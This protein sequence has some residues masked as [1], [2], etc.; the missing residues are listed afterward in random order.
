MSPHTDLRTQL[1]AVARPLS[2]AITSGKGGVGKSIIA[3]SL[4]REQASHGIRTLLVDADLGLGNLHILVDRRPSFTI[5][6]VLSSRCKPEDAVL[7]LEENLWMIAARSGFADVDWD[8]DLN[9]LQVRQMLAW[10]KER[11]SL[12]VFDSGAGI[13]SKVTTLTRLTDVVILV[14]TTEVSAIA[15]SYAVAKYLISEDRS[16]RVGLVVNRAESESEGR[17]TAE[18]VRQMMQKFLGYELPATAHI[19]E[20]EDSSLRQVLGQSG[21]SAG[22]EERWRAGIRSV[23]RIVTECVPKDLSLWADSHWGADE[24]VKK[25]NNRLIDVDTPK[26]ASGRT[27]R[28]EL[29]PETAR[30]DS[31]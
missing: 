10:L 21:G 26:V 14:T 19:C 29:K 7:S 23:C 1:A 8:V 5:E 20:L 4:A 16:A 13:S 28:V 9:M 22:V 15:D 3:L 17:R 6:D 31:L 27:A 12:I 11:F 18:N 25:L 2:V 30:K 24:F